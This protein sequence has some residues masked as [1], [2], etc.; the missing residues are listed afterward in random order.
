MDYLVFKIPIGTRA[1][2]FFFS[3]FTDN[4]DTRPI[5]GWPFLPYSIPAPPKTP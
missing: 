3:K 4:L 5:K 2:Y 1:I